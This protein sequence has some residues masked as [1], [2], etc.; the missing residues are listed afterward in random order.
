MNIVKSITIFLML[1]QN[2]TSFGYEYSTLEVQGYPQEVFVIQVEPEHVHMGS[3]LSYDE[4]FGFETLSSMASRK[5]ATAMV[6]GMF[7]SLFGEPYGVLMEKGKIIKTR[8][9]DLPVFYID[10]QGRAYI[11]PLRIEAYIEYKGEKYPITSYNEGIESANDL[12]LFTKEYGVTN[13]VHKEHTMYEV[14]ENQIIRKERGEKPISFLSEN[15]FLFGS[16]MY[17]IYNRFQ[18]GESVKISYTS[19]VEELGQIEMAIQTGGWVVKNGQ[20]VANPKETFIG[21]TTSLQPRTFVGIGNEGEVYFVVID[22][23]SEKSRGVT[24]KMAG[25][26]LL[27]LGCEQAAYLD[28]GS[29]TEMMVG[30]K[31]VNRPSLGEERKIAHGIYIN[32]KAD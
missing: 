26:I 15:S 29:S 22:G 19:S 11:E 28:G 14:E 1:L 31:V 8:G 23:R 16:V 12:A 21:S 10:K 9:Y 25:E 24:G 30:G 6:N 13:R 3:I 7:Y 2:I 17:G 4:L 18:V 32:R 5:D 27:N 20:N